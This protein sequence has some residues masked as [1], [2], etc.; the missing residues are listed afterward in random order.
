MFTGP[1]KCQNTRARQ[2]ALTTMRSYA[3]C[4]RDIGWPSPDVWDV[5]DALPI[6]L[7]LWLLNYLGLWTSTNCLCQTD[8]CRGADLEKLHLEQGG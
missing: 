8:S 3:W 2:P 4:I 7:C 1:S 5:V 6:Y